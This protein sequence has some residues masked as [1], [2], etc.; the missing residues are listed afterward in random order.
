MPK[1]SSVSLSSVTNF[2]RKDD[3]VHPV[4][5][6]QLKVI[7]FWMN[8][9]TSPCITHQISTTSVGTSMD[10]ELII[11]NPILSRIL[12]EHQFPE[13]VILNRKKGP[14]QNY[15]SQTLKNGNSTF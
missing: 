3:L 6:F 1:N 7:S 10:A 8:T 15:N 2:P 11:V 5:A 9:L 14:L 4:L 12:P 13:G